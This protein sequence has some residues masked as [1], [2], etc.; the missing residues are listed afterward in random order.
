MT[1][2]QAGLCGAIGIVA[3]ATV[4]WWPVRQRILAGDND[5]QHFYVSGELVLRGQLYDTPAFH[6]AQRAILGSERPALLA[7]RPPFFALAFWPW[8]RLPYG[9]AWPIWA[10]VLVGAVVGFVYLWPDRRTAALVCCWSAGIFAALCA[11]QDSPVV[12]L[13]LAIAMRIRDRRPGLAGLVLSLCAA[14]Y[15][16]FLFLPLL[17]WRHKMLRGFAIGGAALLGISFG[18]GGWDWPRRYAATLAEG[19]SPAPEVMPNLNGI[20]AAWAHGWVWEIAASLLVGAAVLAIIRRADFPG[21]LAAVLVGGL[22]VSHHAYLHDCTLLIPALVIAIPVMHGWRLLA[23]VWLLAPM[24]GLALLS[25][26]PLGDITRLALLGF[27][28]SLG[29]SFHAPFWR[30]FARGPAL[31]DPVER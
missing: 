1:R 11:G 12:L 13:W 2:W 8:S 28:A 9:L 17:L 10:G 22:L 29:A 16:L 26:H 27:L 25:G 15:H 19:I 14:K 20:F 21:G 6:A 30:A 24:S 31:P 5:F 7:S 23:L 4:F 3:M 18:A